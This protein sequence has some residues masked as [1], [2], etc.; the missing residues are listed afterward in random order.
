MYIQLYVSGGASPRQTKRLFCISVREL[1]T[2]VLIVCLTHLP[3]ELLNEVL[4][5]SLNLAHY[6]RE[7]ARACFLYAQCCRAQ[8][9]QAEAVQWLSKSVEIYNKLT[10]NRPRT[11]EDL[12]ESDIFGLVVYDN[13]NC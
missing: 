13:I 4:E 1:S 12:T 8:S 9:D 2:P 5:N 10:P 7:V 3:T 6:A 11:E